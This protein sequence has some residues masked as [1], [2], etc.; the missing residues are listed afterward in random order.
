MSYTQKELE[1]AAA[2]LKKA[3]L[4][5]EYDRGYWK[6]YEEGYKAGQSAK[7]P[8]FEVIFTVGIATML[9]CLVVMIAVGAYLSVNP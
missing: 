9:L 8:R 3:N 1:Q 7:F 6:G 4:E 5:E 2:L